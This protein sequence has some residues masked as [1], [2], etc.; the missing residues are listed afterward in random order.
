MKIINRI[1]NSHDIDRISGFLKLA[2]MG[3]KEKFRSL[4]ELKKD[5]DTAAILEP[6]DMPPNVVTMNSE[7]RIE[8]VTSDGSTVVKLVF[9]QEVSSKEGNISLLAPLG[10]ALLGRQRGDL[11][12]YSAPGGEIKVKIDA[13]IFQPESNGDF[14]S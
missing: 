12:S 3:G 10:A 14:I 7:V 6:E 9:P 13:I 11:I 8:G 4:C 1:L 2:T 5:L